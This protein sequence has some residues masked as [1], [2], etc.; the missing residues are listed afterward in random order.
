MAICGT[1]GLEGS[2][3]AGGHGSWCRSGCG[4]CGCRGHLI[5]IQLKLS[6][7]EGQADHP[8]QLLFQRLGLVC[9]GGVGEVKA[10]DHDVHKN[11]QGGYEIGVVLG[12]VQNGLRLLL[13]G[14]QGGG[15]VVHPTGD[16]QELP[17]LGAAVVGTQ[18]GLQ[19]RECG[20]LGGIW[21][22]QS[23]GQSGLSGSP[24]LEHLD[25]GFHI[26]CVVQLP[27]LNGTA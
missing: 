25:D 20:Q 7:V 26:L 1:G 6:G 2:G 17:E 13:I 19:G 27:F 15:Q 12:A 23:L 22:R 10:I 8:I 11:G 21:L 14:V 18:P 9:Y 3:D 4:C 5:R 16:G 24:L